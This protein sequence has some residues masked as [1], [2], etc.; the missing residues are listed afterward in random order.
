MANRIYQIDYLRSVFIILMVIFHLAYI[1]DKYPY[2]K[3]IVYT[4]HMPAFLIISGYLANIKKEKK[5]FIFSILWLFIPYAIMET[6]YV[7]M[8]AILP[9]REKVENVS[10]PLLLNKVFVSPIGP[11]WY[12]HTLIFCYSIYYVTGRIRTRMNEVSFFIVLGINFWLLSDWFHII[13]MANAVY[14][15]I[16]IIIRQCKKDFLSVFQP[17]FLSLFPFLILTY[18]PLNLNRF[19]LAGI[20]IT[21]LS[22]SFSLKVYCYI[23]EKIK[24]ILHFIGKNTLSI[25][26]FSP[27]FTITVK[28][29][30]PLFSFDPSG[31]CFLC[32]STTLVTS[33][34]LFIAWCMDK[35]NL[36]Y[37]FRGKKPTA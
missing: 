32:V 34:S 2:V 24:C 30:I 20:I 19:T 31:L 22:I 36:S 21:Y 11:Y 10:I 7:L 5:Q 33:G 23:P 27:I 6:G 25:L 17:S 37:W 26:L 15:M 35:L 29:L 4:F 13:S 8:S 18:Y 28:V 12:L 16:G 9:V 1:G 3:Q 14:F